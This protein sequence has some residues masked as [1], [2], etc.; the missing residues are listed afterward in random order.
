MKIQKLFF[1]LLACCPPLLFCLPLETKAPPSTT[2]PLLSADEDLMREH[3]IL[4]RVLLIYQEI[5]RRINDN[6]PFPPETLIDTVRLTRD[7]LE[8]F[9][10]ALEEQHVFPYFEK[11]HV[12]VD[13]VKILID[14]H[15]RGRKLIDYLLKHGTKEAIED[16]VQAMVL[17]GYMSIFCRMFRP[18]EAR[19]SSE[20]FPIFP[21]L[22]T[23]EEYQKLGVLFEEQGEQLFGK[24]GFAKTVKKTADIEKQLGLDSLSSY[25]E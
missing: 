10:E 13:L 1:F 15:K 4:N 17:A 23:P 20:L 18:H 3:G 6:I 24:D 22:M 5:A 21:T 12:S 19:E 16:R 11:A 9:H 8:D 14:Q 7:F 25:S 2:K